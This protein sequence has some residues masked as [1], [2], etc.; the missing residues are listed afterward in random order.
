MTTRI[1]TRVGIVGA[2]PRQPDAVPH[3]RHAAQAFVLRRSLAVQFHPELHSDLLAV[4]LQLHPEPRL[5]GAP[6]DVARLRHQT[7]AEQH[8]AAERVR[9]LVSGFLNYAHCPAL[10]P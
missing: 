2:G 6:L 10:S 9:R 5:D 3:A 8:A 1:R 7:K 4:W